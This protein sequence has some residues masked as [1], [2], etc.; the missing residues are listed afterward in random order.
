[1]RK[2]EH[3]LAT[4]AILGS[5]IGGIGLICLASFDTKRHTFAHRFFLFIFVLGVSLSAIFT[6]SEVCSSTAATTIGL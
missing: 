2:R 5:F 1:M 6:V 3:V 4:L